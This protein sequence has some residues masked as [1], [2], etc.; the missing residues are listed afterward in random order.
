MPSPESFK[1]GSAEV[2]QVSVNAE[3]TRIGV[4][5]VPPGDL[6]VVN[7]HNTVNIGLNG[8]VLQRSTILFAGT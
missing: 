8:I 6:L 2:L 3:T 4:G 5:V 7:V 1:R